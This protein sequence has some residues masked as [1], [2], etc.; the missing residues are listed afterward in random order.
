MTK[1]PL[2]NVHEGLT[3]RDGGPY[4]DDEERRLAEIRRAAVEGREPDFENMGAVAGT[5]L[6]PGAYLLDRQ[7][8]NSIPS[9]GKVDPVTNSVVAAAQRGDLNIKVDTHIEDEESSENEDEESS[10]SE[11][12]QPDFP[13]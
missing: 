11:S 3:G 1:G 6:V 9:Q 5:Q 12:D 7:F 8:N 10:E 4:M 2:F 13:M